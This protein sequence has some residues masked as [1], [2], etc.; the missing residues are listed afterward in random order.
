MTERN[1]EFNHFF[2]LKMFLVLRSWPNA[3]FPGV[4]T[5]KPVILGQREEKI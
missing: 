2:F 3:E 5:L 4:K 1:K